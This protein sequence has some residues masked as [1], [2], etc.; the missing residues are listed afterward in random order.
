MN[1]QRFLEEF[2]IEAVKQVTELGY[3]L[4]KV[5]A[6]LGVSNDSL[7]KW[8]KAVTPDNSEKQAAELIEAKS[9]ILRLKALVEVRVLDHIVVGATKTT[10]FPNVA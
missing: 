6:R 4:A 10:S 8:V 2:K 7:Y 9:E 3:S 1:R 5:S